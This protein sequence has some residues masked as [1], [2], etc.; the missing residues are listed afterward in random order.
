MEHTFDI[1]TT[2][3]SRRG[4][5]LNLS[6]PQNPLHQPVGPGL[7]I[8][9]NHSRPLIA[10]ELFKLE[11]VH[12]NETISSRYIATPEM[13]KMIP[14]TG[15]GCV[16]IIAE[17][18]G[19]IRIRGTG[20]GL[21][22]VTRSDANWPV[23]FYD[24]GTGFNIN[25]RQSLRRYHIESIAGELSAKADWEHENPQNMR[26]RN[27]A[28][29]AFAKEGASWEFAIDE[30]GSTWIPRTR[31]PFDESVLDAK[32]EYEDF[33]AR[34]PQTPV[35]FKQARRE[36]GYILWSC[37]KSPCGLFAREPVLMSLNWM[38]GVWNWD[39][40]YNLAALAR[41]EPKLALDQLLLMADNQDEF[42]VYPDVVSDMCRHYNFSKPPVHGVLFNELRRIAPDWWTRERTA[43]IVDTVSRYTNWLLT[44]RSTNDYSL[45][46]YLHGND[47]GWD[48]GSLFDAGVP[49]ISPD[50][51]AFLVEQAVLLSELESE[52]GN[53]ASSEKWRVTA[54]HLTN[55]L[56]KHLWTGEQFA[57]IKIPERKIVTAQS[58][59]DCL[60]IVL[61]K[62]FPVD[63]RERLVS[64]IRTFLCNA[65][66]ATEH[67]NSPHYKEDGYWRGPAWGASTLLTV[68]GLEQA[69]EFDLALDISSR[70]A[71]ACAKFGF[72]EN[73]DAKTGAQFRDP[74][75]TWTA[76][77]FLLL[78]E[79]LT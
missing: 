34:L 32:R 72:A 12:G 68:I 58:F 61:G 4:C 63:V 43:A 2:P 70:F 52:L 50:L 5:W 30:F 71:E 6:C 47:S 10:R 73:M 48:N 42:G 19:T 16:D 20:V 66:L 65:G 64:R 39:N 79:R 33:A 74:S 38:D 29:T 27:I 40:L 62:R 3:F 67:P 76:S 36:A 49:L 23:V 21:R 69:G 77:V 45:C 1:Q 22:I 28:V 51:N 56:L 60:P 17:A 78:A 25:I 11:L 37:A 24:D 41:C 55:S 13:L 44:H 59:M 35:R 7:Y 57:A 46:Y 54:D 75:Y 8:R 14:E 18:P 9:S 15:S 53:T 31:K 26:S